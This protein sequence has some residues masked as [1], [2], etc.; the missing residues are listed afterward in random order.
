MLSK[1]QTIDMLPFEKRS[2]KVNRLLYRNYSAIEGF[3]LL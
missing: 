2:D 1:S 3:F